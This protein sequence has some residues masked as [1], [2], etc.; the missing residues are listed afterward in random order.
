MELEIE[1]IIM[2][3][4]RSWR[5]AIAAPGMAWDMPTVPM[6]RA[7]SYKQVGWWQR[8]VATSWGAL[9]PLALLSSV[10]FMLVAVSGNL[11]RANNPNA[12]TVFWYASALLFVPSAWRLL[13]AST[14]RRERLGL[15]VMFGLALDAIARLFSPSYFD[16]HDEF[17]H[18]RTAS[19]IA[20]T[21][22][23][24][25]TNPLIP[26]SPL[27]PG[28]EIVTQQLSHLSGLSLYASGSVLIA[29]VRV[30]L[31]VTLFLIFERAS[32]SARFAG[33]ATLIYAT[34][35]H[36][37]FFDSAFS[38]ESLALPLSM[39]IV[40]LALRREIG[41][42]ARLRLL[43][44]GM[45]IMLA[46]GVTHHA[47]TYLLIAFLLL[48]ALVA[49]VVGKADARR[50]QP[51][52]LALFGAA[53][54]TFWLVCFAQPV[55]GYL[56]PFVSGS[57]AQLSQIVTGHGGQR[58]LFTDYAGTV[59]PLWDRITM[60]ATVG[61]LT[62]GCL[63]GGWLI[64]RQRRQQVF[65]VTLG[66]AALLYPASQLLRLTPAGA[67]A[68]DRLASFLYVAVAFTA[69]LVIMWVLT[70]LHTPTQ[71]MVGRGAILA[72]LLVVFLG[73]VML[74]SDPTWS[75]LPGPYLVSADSRS[76]EPEGIMSAYWAQAHLAPNQLIFADRTNRLLLAAYGDQAVYTHL[77]DQLDLS[78]IYYS[79]QWT[80]AEI[81]LLR[82]SHVQYLVVD[83][84]LSQQL[85]RLGIYFEDGET[86][87]LQHTTPISSAALAKFGQVPFLQCVYDSGNIHIYQVVWPSGLSGIG[88]GGIGAAMAAR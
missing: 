20:A 26:V 48:W 31:M 3:A 44:L 6:M 60:A 65:A 23:L 38:Y 58:Q 32:Q 4:Q 49:F 46:L 54:A 18:L 87:A 37:L 70:R 47:T 71:R 78:S 14:P 61:L 88:S 7:I 19:D 57:L 36:L 83:T 69:T 8:L 63:F 62:F 40:L 51:L 15:V 52:F 16:Q 1:S 74:G 17:I 12:V 29:V 56:A 13:S 22:H 24:F 2:N 82:Q 73:G 64:W 39:L 72:V 53:F 77:Y 35:P 85:P 50:T 86:G 84:R 45:V 11:G 41:Q 67:E 10:A 75:L 9:A 66:L 5:M 25:T 59:T 30:L 79:N 34:N 81:A 21:G 28:L 80:P 76:I 68:T 43:L 27:F 33:I 55:I 42:P